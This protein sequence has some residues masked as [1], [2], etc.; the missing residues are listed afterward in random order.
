M[1][2]THHTCV[3]TPMCTLHSTVNEN[4]TDR[5]NQLKCPNEVPRVVLQQ[6]SLMKLMHA[7]QEHLAH[8]ARVL[9]CSTYRLPT[10]IIKQ[11]RTYQTFKRIYMR[12]LIIWSNIVYACYFILVISKGTPQLVRRPLCSNT[13]CNFFVH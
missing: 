11:P 3:H 2:F 10:R 9:V 6:E 13:I 4:F 1:S 8:I 7:K 12:L 5:Y